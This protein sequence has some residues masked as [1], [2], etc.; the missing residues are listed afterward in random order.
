MGL[1]DSAAVFQRQVSRA[2][3][4][5][6]GVRAYI[7]D[8]LVY[9]DTIQEHEENLKKVLRALDANDFRIN[10]KKCELRQNKIRFLGHY[11]EVQP[12]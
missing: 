10:A 11:L 5:I 12:G 7:D 4:G 2:L 8:I 1:T 9:G 6:P 3:E